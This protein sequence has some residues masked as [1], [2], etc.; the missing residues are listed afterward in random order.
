MQSNIFKIDY[1]TKTLKR[2]RISSNLVNHNFLIKLSENQILNKIGN[3]SSKVDILV[4]LG[5]NS[6][7]GETFSKNNNCFF[8]LVDNSINFLKQNSSS[9]NNIVVN[10][11]NLPFKQKSISGI[12]SCLYLDSI[13]NSDNLFSNIY[14]VLK[15]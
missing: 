3:F 10:E 7:I 4:E 6:N 9:D 1:K 5:S 2:A 12:I 11:N 13:F 14:N 15:K 8:L